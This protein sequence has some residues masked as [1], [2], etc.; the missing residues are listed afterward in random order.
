[1]SSNSKTTAKG[2]P[3][4]RPKKGAKEIVVLPPTLNDKKKYLCS[5]VRKLQKEDLIDIGK[6]IHRLGYGDK[7]KYNANGVQINLDQ[8]GENSDSLINQ[9][10]SQAKHKID[11]QENEQS[12]QQL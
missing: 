6:N 11:K 2:K 10:Y 7:L 9:I 3:K 1:M 4:G 8:L 5:N 12:A